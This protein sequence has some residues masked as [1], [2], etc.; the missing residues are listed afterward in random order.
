MTHKL[1]IVGRVFGWVAVLSLFITLGGCYACVSNTKTEYGSEEL[2]ISGGKVK[3]APITTT[4]G[5]D[6][7]FLRVPQIAGV[8]FVISL[9]GWM[10]T[11]TGW[12]EFMEEQR[13]KD[14]AEYLAKEKARLGM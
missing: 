7:L 4:T 8:I 11:S 5:G 1:A 9:I 14:A 2:Y 6:G 12:K 3:S 10:M 13:A